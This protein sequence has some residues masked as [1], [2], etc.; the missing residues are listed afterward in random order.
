MHPQPCLGMPSTEL[1]IV[2]ACDMTGV[3][4]QNGWQTFEFV[5]KAATTDGLGETFWQTL[6]S[7]CY[8]Q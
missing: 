1:Q 4:G 3:Y 2:P 8:C 7:L 6:S 5:Y